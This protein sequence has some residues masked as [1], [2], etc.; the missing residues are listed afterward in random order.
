MTRTRYPGNSDFHEVP[1]RCDR[2]GKYV[3]KPYHAE[4]INPH[5]DMPVYYR[6]MCGE[7]S[8]DIVV[9]DGDTE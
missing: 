8:P 3:G 7:C 9:T 5:D 4:Q 1:P 2:C 6:F